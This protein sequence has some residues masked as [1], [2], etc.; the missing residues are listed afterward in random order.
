M[1]STETSQ[2]L[3]LKLY[4]LAEHGLIVLWLTAEH[5]LIRTA[6]RNAR[7]S[8]SELFGQLDLFY[9]SEMQ[10]SPSRRSD[11][12]RLKS[13]RLINP[14]LNLRK[15]LVRLELAS[16][17][18][19]LIISTVEEAHPEPC[20]HQLLS[21]A[22]DYLNTT[23]ASI[24]ILLHFEKRLAALHGLASTERSP[25]LCLLSHFSQLPS[26]RDELLAKLGKV[27]R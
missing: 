5:G 22:L 2:G 6:A 26:G 8:G 9:E 1:T 11:L 27:E 7:K 4:P 12:H 18:S 25:Y 23:P 10:L 13:A 3:I 15:E 24:S 20:W 19:R 21:G 16:Y 17:M 14:R